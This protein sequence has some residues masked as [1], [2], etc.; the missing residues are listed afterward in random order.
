MILCKKSMSIK[1]SVVN[2]RSLISKWLMLVQHLS[3][4]V[5][6]WVFCIYTE[7]SIIYCIS[8]LKLIINS[9]T[10]LKQLKKSPRHHIWMKF[11]FN[12]VALFE[13]LQWLRVAILRGDQFSKAAAIPRN[14]TVAAE[15]QPQLEKIKK[16][17]NCFEAK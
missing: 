15:D 13:M 2:D 12:F 16:C 14:V 7:K 11:N 6:D 4:T 9:N 10:F 8:N 3:C 17:R 5:Y 1:F